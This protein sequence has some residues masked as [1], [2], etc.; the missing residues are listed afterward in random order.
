MDSFIT[1]L[2]D[3]LPAAPN[4]WMKKS[5]ASFDSEK[6]TRSQLESFLSEI[7]QTGVSPEGTVL[8]NCEVMLYIFFQKIP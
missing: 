3:Q 6:K 1:F 8:C 5:M 7:K 4:M 2:D